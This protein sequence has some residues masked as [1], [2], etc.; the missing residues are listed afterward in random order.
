[1]EKVTEGQLLWT[2]RVY[3]KLIFVSLK[4]TFLSE[5]YSMHIVETTF[6]LVLKVW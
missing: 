3:H 5:G 1:M 4:A 2:G 6:Q